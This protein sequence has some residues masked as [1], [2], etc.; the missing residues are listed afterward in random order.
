ML[1]VIMPGDTLVVENVTGDDIATG[2]IIL[3]HRERRFFVHRVVHKSEDKFQLL[4]RG[5]AMPQA[6]PPVMQNEVL[7]RILHIERNGKCLPPSSRPTWGERSIAAIVQRSDIAAR[8]VVGV[9]GMLQTTP[10]QR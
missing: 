6:D 1:P 9:H 4:T 2:E 7:G 5:D 8:V 3:F 10:A